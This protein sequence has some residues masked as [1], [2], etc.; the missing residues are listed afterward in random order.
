MGSRGKTST[1]LGSKMGFHHV[2][3]AGLE[4]LAS[5][6]PPAL[7][8]QSAGITDNLTLSPRLECSGEMSAH[9]NLRLLGSKLGSPYVAQAGLELLV[10]VIHPPQPPKVSNQLLEITKVLLL[11]PKL[12]CNGMIS[13]H[14]NLRLPG[15]GDSPASAYQVAGI[16]GSGYVTQAGLE[17]LSSTCFGLPKC[18]DYR[19]EPPCWSAVAQSR[20]T[21]AWGSWAQVILLPQSLKWSFALVAQAGVQWCNLGSLQPPPPEFK[22]FSCLS[23]PSSWDYR[24]APLRLANFVFLVETGF[25]RVGQAGL[26]LPSSGDPPASASQSAG[27]TGDCIIGQWIWYRGLVMEF[28]CVGFSCMPDALLFIRSEG[29]S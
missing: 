2:G 11:L 1:S 20:L 9:C 26:E 5:G 23:L 14:C 3:Q 25:L 21:A 28:I 19:H 22:Q 24:H 29:G 15:S 18:W 16:T 8:Y 10:S 7:A 6:D 27:I 17:L 4:L 12:E 13:A